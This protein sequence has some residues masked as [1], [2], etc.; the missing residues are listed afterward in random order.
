LPLQ[1]P[2]ENEYSSYLSSHAGHSNA[3]TAPTQTNYFFE[4]A[5]SSEADEASKSTDESSPKT[6][7]VSAS[8][9]PFYG[10][11]DRFA[12]FFV[13]P[14]FLESTLDRELR[15]VDSENKKNLQS[16]QWR[17]AQLSRSLSNPKHPFSKFST[18]NLET[19]RDVPEKQGVKI[20]A[21]FIEFYDKH[22]SANLMKLVVLG[23]EPLDELEQ[24]VAELFSDVKNKDLPEHR[25]D[26][27][28]QP[29][30]EAELSTQV[31]AKPV[32][33]SRTLEIWFP[34]RDEEDMFET[35]P[36]RF[37][38]HL[39][40]HEGPGSI[41]A[42]L[43]DKGWANDLSCG[44]YTLCPGTAFFDFE[45][46]LT[47]EG[48]QKY[49]EIL[50]VVF[51][52][53]AM[54]KEQPPL[55]WMFDE[56]KNM[57][58]VNFRFKQKTPASRFTMST[59]SVMQKPIPRN[60]LLSGS[61][62]LRKFDPV[63]I[64][65][66]M[67]YL[68][69]DNFR[70][71]V[72]SQNSPAEFDKKER[73]YGTEYTVGKI[74]ETLTSELEKILSD[75]AKDRPA[76]LHLPHRNEFIP[77]RLD[78]EKKEVKEP[79][80]A[81]KL[82]R[83][84]DKMRLWWK[85]DDRFWVPKTN[86]LVTIRSPITD[87]TP[88]N[89]VK[90]RLLCECVKDSLSEYSYDADISGLIYDTSVNAQGLDIN[91]GGYSDK[92]PVLLEKVVRSMKDLKINPDRFEV[93]KERLTR[94]YKNFDYQQP[95]YQVGSYTKWLNHEKSWINHQ[96]AAE[97]PNIQVED[98]QAFIPQVLGQ[99][100]IE[101]LAHGNL[102]K[103][104]ALKMANLVESI[105]KPRPLPQ[106]LWHLRRNMLLPV[107]SNFI[108]PR[109]LTDRANVNH[110]IE[111]SLQI[112][113]RTDRVL[114][115]KTQLFAQ[116]LQEPTFDQLRTKE[117][118]GYVVFSGPQLSVATMFYRV[119]VQSERDPEYLE[120]RIEAHL[121]RYGGELEKMSDADFEAHRR[122]V[123]NEKQEKLKN[124]GSE[125]A[126][127][128]DNIGNEYFD[129][130][131][132]DHDVDELKKLTRADILDFYNEFISPLSKRRAKLS[133]HMISQGKAKEEDK[134]APE[135]QIE[136]ILN[137]L[138]QFLSTSGAKV[139]TENLK[140]DLEKVDVAGGDQNGIIAVARDYAQSSLPAEQLDAIVEQLNEAIPQLFVALGIKS[141]QAKKQEDT[142]PEVN[143]VMNGDVE[144]T[145]P[146]I[147]ENVDTWKA[148]LRV[149]EGPRAVVDLSEF[150]EIEPK[151]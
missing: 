120:S 27:P 128:A 32:M 21:K 6:N 96:Y 111:Y 62:K 84:D 77:T 85:K 78:V 125:T 130:Y 107:G 122:S 119:L 110:S 26:G 140:V 134:V 23:K 3:Y 47:T 10:A 48:L 91:I 38:S 65:S 117:Q 29:F 136:A 149:S 70:L 20:R 30:T 138:S 58:D 145:P 34:Y 33:E 135:K 49:Q 31:F 64:V 103:E 146:V 123:I 150:E 133:V 98:V 19:L 109:K 8:R 50:K 43:K 83:N 40:G 92:L 137:A 76:A 60:W 89:N 66:G 106:S 13:E 143:G 124:L 36:S 9:S 74:P 12:Q 115:V 93:I 24:W 105:L 101:I 14:L 7:G 25:W 121:T 18:G 112:G 68:R 90:S 79:A 4:C 142:V 139:D 35:Q 73:W 39:L 131:R 81:P 52:Y 129:F 132:L 114:K 108:Y 1:Y 147:I 97:L 16:D 59:S 61:T 126:R 41:F 42:Y 94:G 72:V 45:V 28:E 17:L 102:H 69:P 63:A 95:Y 127:L 86:F 5:S 37:L 118:L 44:Y 54:M 87:S 75:G 22:Y 141:A 55:Q 2:V 116:I 100:H 11:L 80:K 99:N 53:S 46:K 15:A 104:D 71:M 67:E 51:Q 56:M 82:I 88:A 113:D 144:K 57:G 151:L 148:G